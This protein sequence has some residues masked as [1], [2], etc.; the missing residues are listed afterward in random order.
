MQAAL[1]PIAEQRAERLA[2]AHAIEQPRRFARAARRQ[3]DRE[4]T[5][6]RRGMPLAPRCALR[7]SAAAAACVIDGAWMK[8][9]SSAARTAAPARPPAA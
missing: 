3:I 9:V 6:A 7:S 2:L 5:V 4:R 1:E 8:P